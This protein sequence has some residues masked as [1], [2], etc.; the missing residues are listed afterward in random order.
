MSNKEEKL[1]E[2]YSSLLPYLE[3]LADSTYEN[4]KEILPSDLKNI[5]RIS[6]RVKDEDS[7]LQKAFRKKDNGDLKYSE[8]I[9]EIQDIIGLRLVVFYKQ[10]V[11][12]YVK[13]ILNAYREIEDQVI[14]PDDERKFGYEGRHF[15]LSI[16]PQ[17]MGPYRGNE[18]IPKFFELQIKTLYEHAWSESNHDLIYKPQVNI[19]PQMQRS[20]AFIAAQS[21]GADKILSELYDEIKKNHRN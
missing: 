15:I 1:R 4:L 13:F 19:T 16:P 5:D 10:D 21:W 17:L 2:I 9:Y 12:Y 14:V 20:M 7:F 11:E 3:K 18:S 8:P 6:Y